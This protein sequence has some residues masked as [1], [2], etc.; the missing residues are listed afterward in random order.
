MIAMTF[1]PFV[2]IAVAIAIGAALYVL[3]QLKV[4]YKVVVLPTSLFW[5]QAV[6]NTPVRILRKRFRYWL[7]YLL[8][9]LIALLLWLAAAQPHWTGGAEAPLHIFYLDASATMT[10]QNRFDQAR[11][12]MLSDLKQVGS[13]QRLVYVGGADNRLL[14]ARGESEAQLQ[15]RLNKAQASLSPSGFSQFIQQLSHRYTTQAV[16]LHYYGSARETPA[17]PQNITLLNGYQAPALKDNKGIVAIGA[18][19]A[20]SGD[21][22]RVDVLIRV[23]GETMQRNDLQIKLDGKPLSTR[24]IMPHANAF[25]L[26]DIAASGQSLTVHLSDADD[27][28]ADND[29]QLILPDY[30]PLAVAIGPD[31]PESIRDVIQA[32]TRLSVVAIPQAQVVI[33]RQ[34]TLADVAL[35]ALILTEPQTQPQAFVLRYD[36]ALDNAQQLTR[37]FTGLGLNQSV[38]QSLANTVQRPVTLTTEPATIRSLAIWNVL[39][40]ARSDFIK[41]PVMPNLVTRTLYWLSG[42][43]PWV[44]YAKAGG[45][46]TDLS[47][48]YSLST[49]PALSSMTLGGLPYLAQAGTQQMGNTPVH[50]AIN[51]DALSAAVMAPAP[52]RD[53]IALHSPFL[54]HYLLPLLV[55]LAALLLAVEWCLV[56][57]GKMP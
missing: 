21:R 44:P 25:L 47:T 22:Q 29:A 8:S 13:E 12:A 26:P 14:V 39:F 37:N 50:V 55:L 34:G 15:T 31:I 19:P 10:A 35:P 40:N 7:A 51:S 17:L 27:F 38:M 43:S 48:D 6:A 23:T 56:Q 57:R 33:R 49:S 5:R 2:V 28:M 11:D 16:V 24:L 52:Q 46:I 4:R 42:Q 20:V 54:L 18:T 45:I 36:Q 9:L 53:T 30:T 32:D 41:T 3:Q 1:S